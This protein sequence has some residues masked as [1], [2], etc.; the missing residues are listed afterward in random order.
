MNTYLK[1]MDLNELE[2][3]TGGNVFSDVYKKM[4]EAGI[5]PLKQGLETV[6]SAAKSVAKSALDATKSVVKTVTNVVHF[7]GTDL[8]KYDL[9]EGTDTDSLI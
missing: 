8:V 1:E 2:L 6:A 5:N 7:S 9:P 3:V 4:K